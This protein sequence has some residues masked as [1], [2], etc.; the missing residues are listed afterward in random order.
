MSES[1]FL[2]PTASRG[3]LSL[4][5]ASQMDAPGWR[6]SRRPSRQSSR[7]GFGRSGMVTET[8]AAVLLEQIGSEARSENGRI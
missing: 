1:G 3:R 4:V 7:V 6:S 2:T 5:D 8:S